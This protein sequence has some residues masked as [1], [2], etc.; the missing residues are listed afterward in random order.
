VIHSAKRPRFWG[1]QATAKIFSLVNFFSG[2]I[3]NA[4]FRSGWY[5]LERIVPYY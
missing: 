3:L 4:L 2:P 1:F 5:K